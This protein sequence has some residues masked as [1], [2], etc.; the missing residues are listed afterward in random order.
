MSQCCQNNWIIA[1]ISQQREKAFTWEASEPL[2]YPSHP[3]MSPSVLVAS[4]LTALWRLV[5]GHADVLVM[6]RVSY[7]WEKEW[8]FEITQHK[9]ARFAL[10][11]TFC[12]LLISI[13]CLC[14]IGRHQVTLFRFRTV[15]GNVCSGSARPM[16]SPLGGCAEEGRLHKVQKITVSLRS[17][18]TCRLWY[19]CTAVLTAT[20]NHGKI[21]PCIFFFVLEKDNSLGVKLSKVFVLWPYA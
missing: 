12:K 13:W 17:E 18:K 9:C 21:L 15:W 8:I 20:A 11:L 16:K 3:I 7:L 6:R 14:E 4:I 1:A 5:K 10:A 2:N 19:W